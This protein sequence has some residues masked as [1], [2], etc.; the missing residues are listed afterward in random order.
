MENIEG[1]EMIASVALLGN[2]SLVH[3][4]AQAFL[5]MYYALTQE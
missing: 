5:L 2:P 1:M 3:S 4:T